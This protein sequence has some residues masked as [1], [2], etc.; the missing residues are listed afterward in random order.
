MATINVQKL[1]ENFY[2]FCNEKLNMADK[3]YAEENK[4]YIFGMI[5][6]SHLPYYKQ[7]LNGNAFCEIN[8]LDGTQ[9]TT[10]LD[11]SDE[12]KPE[13]PL[14]C[15][16]EISNKC[17][18]NCAFCYAGCTPNGKHADIKKFIEDKNSFLYTLHEGTEL[19]LNGNEPL[20]PDL[21]LLLQ[22]LK[23]RGII[24]NLTVRENT[25]LLH[26]NEIETWLK[27]GLLHGVGISP[28]EYSLEMVNWCK[29]HPTAVI[30]TIAGITSMN[31]YK[32]LYDKDL[33]ILILGYKDFGRGIQYANHNPGQI[34]RLIETL[35][36]EVPNFINHFKVVSFDNLAIKQL[37]PD[38][39]LSVEQWETFYRGDDGH[40][41]LMLNLVDETFAL[42]SMQPRENHIPIKNDIRDMLNDIHKLKENSHE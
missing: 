21:E 40:H 23:E 35:S 30:H 11:G 39:W 7:F 8:T 20:H 4:E 6:R 38:T 10:V 1:N 5:E 17:I 31:Q 14:N 15:D 2:K 26:K 19:A 32:Q 16:M 34:E 13:F 12:F 41:T 27:D 3:Q 25:L 42:N 24:A 9:I 18:N 29:V 37:S 33:K 28:S 36:K 22:F